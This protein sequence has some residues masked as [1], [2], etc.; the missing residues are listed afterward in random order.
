[1]G[2]VLVTGFEPFGGDAVNPS[3]EA[4]QRLADEI[5]G[6]QLTKLRLPVVFGKAAA[7]AASKAREI[8]ADCILCVGLAGGRAAIT[9][10]YIGVNLRNARIPDNDGNTYQDEPAVAG[11]P[12][13][14]FATIPVR[15][16]AKAIADAGIP[17]SVSMS[18]GAYVCNDT[19][20]S[21]LYAFRETPVK[22]GFIH[23]PYLPEQSEKGIPLDKMVKAL[24]IAVRNLDIE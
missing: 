17:A 22:V 16:I 20:Y 18:A 10:E 8:S 9:P 3:W 21:L 11:G 23:V 2:R 15:R 12:D 6:V 24:T 5:D 13:G 7:M 19:L 1:M 14:I 4:V